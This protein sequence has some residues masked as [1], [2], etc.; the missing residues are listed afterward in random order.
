M[1]GGDGE[2]T[3]YILDD[4]LTFIENPQASNMPNPGSTWHYTF[5]ATKERLLQYY[6]DYLYNLPSA[7][8]PTSNHYIFSFSSTWPGDQTTTTTA[9]NANDTTTASS[10]SSTTIP[11]AP[12]RSSPS[13]TNNEMED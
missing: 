7:T 2:L 13:A 1:D 6:D 5:R 10:S 3:S 4:L 12:T 9:G 11:P 8:T